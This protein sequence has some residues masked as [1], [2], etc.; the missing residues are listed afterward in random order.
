MSHNVWCVSLLEADLIC[1]KRRRDHGC[2]E[3][4]QRCWTAGCRL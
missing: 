3:F 1:R 2:G 4:T